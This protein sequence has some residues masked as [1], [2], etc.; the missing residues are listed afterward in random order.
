MRVICDCARHGISMAPRW[1]L[2]AASR[3]M[4]DD[5][6]MTSDLLARAHERTGQM[7]DQLR[8]LVE[9]ESPSDD[10]TALGACADLIGQ[11]WED[12]TG[13]APRRV[14]SDGRTHLLWESAGPTKVL[15]LGH[16]DTVWPL[17][18]INELPFSNI[19][20]V[21]RGPGTLDMKAGII[22]ALTAISLL[23]DADGVAVLL[24]ADEE[25]GAASSR[26]LIEN[27]ARQANAV[28]VC[29]PCTPDGAVKIARR[30][31][32][33]YRV[34]VEGRAAHAGEEPE[35]GINATIEIASQ[36]PAIAAIASTDLDTT[37]TPTVLHAG[38]TVNSVPER[39][40][41]DIDVRGWTRTE[42]ERV[43]RQLRDL[44]PNLPG[45]RL[46][47]TGAISRGSF[48]TS[49]SRP[50]LPAVEQAAADIGIPMPP[51]VKWRSG[52]DANLTAAIGTPTLD[53]LGA[54]GAHPHSRDEHI[55]ADA[56]PTRTAFLAA[57]IDQLRQHPLTNQ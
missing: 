22:Q 40:V 33:H 13:R 53:G 55:I 18:T 38:T 31:I 52:S 44:T 34:S 26:A 47:V 1:H 4:G 41:L 2:D 49:A 24:T 19:D 5:G 16:Y 25:V 7:V 11:Q 15:L 37:V 10:V 21:I 36:I 28:L 12:A 20:G 6:R 29:E 27:C 57:L 45:A 42:L 14:T 3:G 23:D 17:G 56:M 35:R 51:T 48:E 39:A 8:V 30:G 50:L 32:A 54:Q 46:S 9:R 43:D